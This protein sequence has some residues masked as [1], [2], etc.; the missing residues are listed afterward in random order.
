PRNILVTNEGEPKLL[1]FGI[2]KILEEDPVTGTQSNTITMIRMMTPEYA[3]PEQVR[4]AAVSTA[5]DVY[6]LGVLLY[7]LLTG[8]R[9]YRLKGRLPHEAAEV[10]CKEDPPRPSLIVRRTVAPD[11]TTGSLE[12]TPELV[13]STRE[14]RPAKLIRAL[15]GDLDNIV[16]KA[17]E[18]DPAR[19]Y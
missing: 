10:V 3:S 14:G 5:S 9:P 15:G 4:G 7:E 2:A 1:D 11:P 18:K 16:L 17:L 13:S 6:S 8:H 12:L 19:R